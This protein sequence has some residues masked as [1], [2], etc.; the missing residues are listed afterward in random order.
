MGGFSL[1]QEPYLCKELSIE[2]IE[3]HRKEI[4]AIFNASE[5]LTEQ[6]E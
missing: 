5:Y 3:R 1:D 6:E 4:Y 2:D